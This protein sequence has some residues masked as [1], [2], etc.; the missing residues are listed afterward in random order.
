MNIYFVSIIVYLIVLTALALRE[1]RKVTSQEEFSV[2]GRQLSAFVLFGTMLAT[3]IGTGSI[4]GNAEKTYQVGI[5]A[6]IIPVGGIAGIIVLYFL[7][8]RVRMMAQITIQDLLEKRYNAAARVFGVVTLVI[9][10]VTIVSYQY[11]AAGAVLHLAKPEISLF[12]ATILAAIF[13]ILF[14]SLAGMVSIA[15]IGVVQGITMIVG[16]AITLPLLL[17]AAGGLEG[18]HQ[19]LEASHFDFLGPI[20]PLEAL[21]ILLPIFLLILGDANMYQRF[22]SAQSSGVARKGVLMTVFGIAFMEWM[23]ILTAWVASS[24]E[25]DLANDGHVIAYAARNHLP[26]AVGALMLVTIVAIVL[27]TAGSYLL[28]PA[29]CL[30]RD[31]VQRFLWKDASERS[32]VTTLRLSVVVLGIAAWG[33]SQASDE[34]LSVALQAYTIY[35]A[36]ITPALLACFFW[37]RATSAGAVA[38]IAGG[39]FV[40]LFWEYV[41]KRYV[42][43]SI[44]AV[45]PALG[46]SL[47]LLIVVSLIT[48]RS[49]DERIDPFF[50]KEAAG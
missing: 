24:L 33:L 36:G 20:G 44:D 10:Y 30:V 9:A 41:L 31:I 43:T 13:I 15:Y 40:T 39:T 27:S 14:T 42:D 18:M 3:W 6:W 45:I 35:G 12:W 8:G 16:I 46:T 29:T 32:L 47:L 2:A 25:G 11:R 26:V 1:S 7:A 34:F 23:I 19:R 38:S 49:A 21:N 4:F 50:Q 28:A 22:S 17:S 37:K 5:A 48:K